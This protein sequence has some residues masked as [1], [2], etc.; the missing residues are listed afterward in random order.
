MHPLLKN[1]VYISFAGKAICL[2]QNLF[3]MVRVN[4][5]YG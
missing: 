2:N 3:I 4:E 1:S 5:Q